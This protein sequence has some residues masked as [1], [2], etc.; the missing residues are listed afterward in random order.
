MLAI[1]S[2]RSQL[3]NP[4]PDQQ[5]CYGC[6]LS[7]RSTMTRPASVQISTARVYLFSGQRTRLRKCG[8]ERGLSNKLYIK[9]IKYTVT[10]LQ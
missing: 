5:V 8:K 4:E 7:G 9:Q 6:V 3:K 2:D 10:A 1:A